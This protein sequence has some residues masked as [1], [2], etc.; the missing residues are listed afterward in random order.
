[1]FEEDRDKFD[2][3]IRNITSKKHHI[4]EA[5]VFCMDRS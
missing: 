1:M 3:M 4:A 2:V 5:M